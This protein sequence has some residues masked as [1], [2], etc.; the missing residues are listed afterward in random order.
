VQITV[1]GNSGPYPGP[2]TVCSGYLLETDDI[3]ILLD[4]GSG[5]LSALQRK[6]SLQDLDAV[7]LS[8]LHADH[9]SDMLVMRYALMFEERKYALPVYMPSQP[10][11]EAWL[12]S[13]CKYFNPIEINHKKYYTLG[14]LKIYFT[15]V[16]HPVMAYATRIEKNG[17][18]FVYSGDTMYDENLIDFATNADLF[19]CDSAF[20]DEEHWPEAPH[21]S[22]KQAAQMALNAKAKRLMIT[23]FSPKADRAALLGEAK[24]TFPNTIASARDLTIKI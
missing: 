2:G 14:N 6:C 1:L 10:E 13:G 8:H 17:T 15:P 4:C 5:V 19:I 18:A 11:S 7:I 9:M 12:L 20:S 23:H 22:A 3:K 24:E 21:A 16:M